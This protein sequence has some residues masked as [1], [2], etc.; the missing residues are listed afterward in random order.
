MSDKL[1]HDYRPGRAPLSLR[2]DLDVEMEGLGHEAVQR[3]IETTYRGAIT[4]H[5]Q[6]C[7]GASTLD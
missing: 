5:E 1:E 3:L 6:L 4:P 7:V 2:L